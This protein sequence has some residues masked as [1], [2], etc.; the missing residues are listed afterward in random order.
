M[1]RDIGIRDTERGIKSDVKRHKSA[2]LRVSI[3]GKK[4]AEPEVKTT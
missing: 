3:S 2:A 1:R 4:A